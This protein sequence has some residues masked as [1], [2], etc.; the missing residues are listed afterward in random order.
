MV[1]LY[2]HAAGNGGHGQ[3]VT[4]GRDRTEA[5]ARM[6]RA[7]GMFVVEGIH[8]SI[9]LQQKVMHDPDFQA[10]VFDTNFIKRFM[11]AERKSKQLAAD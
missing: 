4:Y 2:V 3:E 7:L 8:T 9:P 5:I 6:N 1:T 11:P 10:G